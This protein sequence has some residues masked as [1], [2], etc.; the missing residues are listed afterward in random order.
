MVDLCGNKSSDRLKSAIEFSKSE[1]F[2]RAIALA[3][4]TSIPMRGFAQRMESRLVDPNRPWGVARAVSK[5]VELTRKIPSGGDLV[6]E[7]VIGSFGSPGTFRTKARSALG[8]AAVYLTIIW[9]CFN[10]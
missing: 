9:R 10:L 1:E 8:R 7:F 6:A 2:D 3:L 4:I 5:F